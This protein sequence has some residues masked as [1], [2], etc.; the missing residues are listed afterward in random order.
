ML[1]YIIANFIF[2]TY[3]RVFVEFYRNL[4]LLFLPPAICIFTIFWLVRKN[5]I[6]LK[7]PRGLD[8]FEHRLFMVTGFS[9]GYF[10]AFCAM[11]F[12]LA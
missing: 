8:S 12:F 6:N 5:K 3:D 2:L 10:L 4:P 1:I 7:A 11:Y 9:I